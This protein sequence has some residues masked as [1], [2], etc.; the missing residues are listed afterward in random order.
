MGAEIDVGTT[1]VARQNEGDPA[2]VEQQD[3]EM[4]VESFLNPRLSNV[5]RMMARLRLEAEGKRGQKPDIQD[6]LE[7]QAKTKAWPKLWR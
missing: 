7:L 4:Q 3:V 2:L 1:P 6:V 5:D